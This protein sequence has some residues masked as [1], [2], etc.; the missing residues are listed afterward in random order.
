MTSVQSTSGSSLLDNW[1]T[2][3]VAALGSF[4]VILDVTVVAIALPSIER[5]LKASFAE[6]QW[7]INAYNI[8]YTSVLIA[9]GAIADWFG[10]RRVMVIGLALFGLTSLMVGLADTPMALILGRVAQGLSASAM[11]ILGVAL[12]SNAFQGSDRAQAFAIWGVSIGCGAAFGPIVGGVLVDLL[13]WRW[14]FLLNVPI[15]AILIALCYWRVEESS[16]DKAGGLDWPGIIA[17]TGAL[18]CL[19]YAVI[20]GGERGWGSNTIV[21][22]IVGAVVL[23]LAFVWIE[24][25]VKKPAFDLRLFRIPTFT[26]IQLVCVLNS[27]TFWVMLVYLP[28]YF[29][30]VHGMSAS[31]AGLML[32]PMTVPLLLFAPLGARLAAPERLGVRGLIAFGCGL[33]AIGFLWLA[34][35]PPAEVALWAVAFFLLGIGTGLINGELSNVATAVV[36]PERAG[37]ASG[38]NITFRHGSFTLSISVF[39]AILLSSVMLQLGGT[40]ELATALGGGLADTANYIA[41]GDFAGAVASAPAEVQPALETFGRESFAAAFSVLVWIVAILSV[42]AIVVSGLMI[43]RQDLL[44]GPEAQAAAAGE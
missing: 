27:I 22:A 28:I 14:I 11:L 4:L 39:G 20:E 21:A 12:I 18:A 38:V 17:F 13:S 35:A 9:V 41:R 1:P 7:I 10:R 37:V 8:A 24:M 44:A 23:F 26:G 5:E 36:P 29:Q 2:L 15:V 40:G 32:M 3:L 6:L 19:S 42:L 16:D 34:I 43:R 25:S 33:V 31:S 30:V